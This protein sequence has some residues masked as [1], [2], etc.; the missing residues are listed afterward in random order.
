VTKELA[1]EQVDAVDVTAAP[2]RVLDQRACCLSGVQLR[3]DAGEQVINRRGVVI[4]KPSRPKNHVPCTSSP[5]TGEAQLPG[6]ARAIG[7]VS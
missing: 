2:D 3:R 6:S 4:Q 5:F 1:Q 7:F